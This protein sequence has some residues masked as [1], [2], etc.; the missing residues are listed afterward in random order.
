M[1]QMCCSDMLYTFRYRLVAAAR[2]LTVRSSAD[3]R[4]NTARRRY[5]GPPRG[6]SPHRVY[7]AAA[8]KLRGRSS[9]DNHT[10][11]AFAEGILD[12]F[13]GEARAGFTDDRKARG[14]LNGTPNANPTTKVCT[15]L[16]ADR[17]QRLEIVPPNAVHRAVSY[18]LCSQEPM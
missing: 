17:N 6:R 9:A 2:M 3:T 13:A 15:T 10:N 7:V 11:T 1:G 5:L 16:F 12:N 14:R 8:R 4:T 18:R